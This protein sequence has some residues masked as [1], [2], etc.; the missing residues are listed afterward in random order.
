MWPLSYGFFPLKTGSL[1]KTLHLLLPCQVVALLSLTHL[2]TWGLEVGQITHLHLIT[3]SKQFSFSSCNPKLWT[4][5]YQTIESTVSHFSSIPSFIS[6]F[7]FSSSRIWLLVYHKTFFSSASISTQMILPM[8]W[9]LGYLTS[10]LPM[11][12]SFPATKS[13]DHALEDLLTTIYGNPNLTT[14]LSTS[15]SNHWFQLFPLFIPSNILL[16]KKSVLF[17]IKN[18]F[19]ILLFHSLYTQIPS[20]NS[21]HHHCNY[22]LTH[23]YHSLSFFLS[24]SYSF[25]ETLILLKSDSLPNPFPEKNLKWCVLVLLWSHDH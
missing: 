5:R 7:S 11:I 3:K 16:N 15:F 22:L 25:S 19:I 1:L 14:I 2:T 17:E 20:L 12:F 21:T 4:P 23:V 9:T 13:S 24:L 6:F 18:P 10:S 8:L